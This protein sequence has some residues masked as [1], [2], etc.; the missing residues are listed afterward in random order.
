MTTKIQAVP[1]ILGWMVWLAE[2]PIEF[3]S[4]RQEDQARAWEEARRQWGLAKDQL[5]KHMVYLDISWSK[6][7]HTDGKHIQ[8]RPLS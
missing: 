7:L 8:S 1:Y 4:L 5:P 2:T 6:S 3:R